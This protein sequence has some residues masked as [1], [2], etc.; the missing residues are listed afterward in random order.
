MPRAKR[1]T[2]GARRRRDVLKEAKSYYGS[3]HR[4][5]RTAAESVDKALQHA[6]IG[7]KLKKRDFRGLWQTRIAAAAKAS[8]TSYSKLIGGLKKKDSRI[9]R[10]V[11]SE[12]ALNYP[13]DFKA[14]VEWVAV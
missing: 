3:R 11:L 9:N 10:K 6:Y 13:D 12:L 5:L 2:K 14:L 1:G 7:R 8:G 4:L